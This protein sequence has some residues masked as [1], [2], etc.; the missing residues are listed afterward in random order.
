MRNNKSTG[1]DVTPIE[2]RN[3]FY[4]RRD[5]I[6]TSTKMFNK[7]KKRKNFHWAGNLLSYTQFKGGAET[8]RNQETTEDSRFCWYLEEY[9]RAS[10]LAD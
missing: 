5:A 9:F 7:I 1:Y 2:F 4:I 10:W 6:E 8:K 3:V